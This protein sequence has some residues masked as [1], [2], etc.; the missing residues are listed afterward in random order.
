MPLHN[1][2]LDDLTSLIGHWFIGRSK[3]LKAYLQ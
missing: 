3:S 1:S 2:A